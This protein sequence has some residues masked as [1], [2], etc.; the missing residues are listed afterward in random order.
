MV[1]CSKYIVNIDYYFIRETSCM[2]TI[3]MITM[4]SM[5]TEDQ[6]QLQHQQQTIL[7][8]ALLSQLLI[9]LQYHKCLM[10]Y[11]FI[12]QQMLRHGESAGT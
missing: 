4:P 2:F 3:Q 5:K 6:T 10:V 8:H 12:I 9:A 7:L 1:K 11:L